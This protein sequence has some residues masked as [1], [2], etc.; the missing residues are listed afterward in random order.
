MKDKIFYMRIWLVSCLMAALGFF[1]GGCSDDDVEHA[2]SQYGYVQFKLFKSGSYGIDT[3]A[4]INEL[5][6]LSEAQKM[7]IVLTNNEDATEVVQT[8]NLNAMGNDKELG[9]RSEKL[10][11]MAGDY[12]I[13]GFWLY[14][15]EGQEL[16]P[17][18]SGEPA[19]QTA[20]RV[21][22]GG[23]T[24]QDIVVKVVERGS[25]KFTL[26]KEMV[27]DTKAASDADNFL[28][29]DIAYVTVYVRNQFSEKTT[30]FTDVPVKYKEKSAEGGY[31]YAVAESDSIFY[32]PAGKYQIYSYTLKD[33]N[34]KSFAG[35]VAEA[36]FEVTDNHTT[37]AELPVKLYATAG[38]IQDYLVLKEIWEALDGPNWS[39][40]GETYAKGVNWNFDKEIDMWGEQPGV[41]TDAKGRVT[42]LNLGSFGPKGDI[43][44]S[45]GQLT[46]LKILTLGTHSDRVGDNLIEQWGAEMTPAQKQA[47]RDDYYNKFVKRDARENCSEVLQ[48]AFNLQGKPV[49]KRQPL[50][51]EGVSVKDV[52][53][54]KRT[55]AIRGVPKEIG[56]LTKLQ[57]FF[58]ANG[59]FTDFEEGTDLSALENLTD[60]EIYNCPDMKKLPEALFT[61]PNIELLN[62]ANNPQIA[63]ADFEEGLVK[64]A[65]GASEKKLQILYL[66]NNKI[67]RIPEEFKNLEKLG[68]LDCTFNQIKTIPAFG[69]KVSFVQLNFDY[70]Q[71]EEVPRDAE[72]YFCGYED[73]EGISF[74]HNKIKVFPNMFD[75]ASVYGVGSVDFSFNEITAFEDGENFRGVNTKTLSLTGNKLKT[76]P[77]ILIEKNSI[78]SILLLNGNGMEEFP[79]GSL[80]GEEVY[81]L[82][83]LDLTYNRLSKLPKEFNAVSLPY[84]YGL[85]LSYNCF[86]SFPTSPLNIDHLTVFGLRN[87]K[88]ENGDRIMREWP[89][90]ISQCPSL[91][92]L[93]LGGNDLRKI[94]DTISPNI[95]IFEIKDNPNIVIDVSSVCA[96]IK[97]GYY[98]LVYDPTQDIRGCD[99]LDLEK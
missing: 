45:I 50:F 20:I 15:V 43:P 18:V 84:L 75:A 7:K 31:E 57:Q 4:G 63:S 59:A 53:P 76:F 55:N 91:R 46:E 36:V 8:V 41:D 62:L 96:Y 52:T 64:L 51:R 92:I 32:L 61:C 66:G 56:Q 40:S 78:I 68:K 29:S 21:T 97:A 74:A 16:V 82:Q 54:G 67:T 5:D 81:N 28:F 89:T 23:L 13:V 79:D 17:V 19:E 35:D 27:K 65:T 2:D 69:K 58:I 85:D 24:V 72:G 34:K 9:L 71:I 11:L 39:Y 30:T 93:M 33:K 94:D 22:G 42:V 49:E 70:N 98:Q 47:C 99:A 44:A 80:K 26:T 86:S 77:K 90:G 3:R 83:T 88:N 12:T 37:E 6:Y 10:Q 48:M 1:L 25:L 14:A 60:I 38:R 73:M 95:Y 87:Q